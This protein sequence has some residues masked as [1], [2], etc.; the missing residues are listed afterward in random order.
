[1][2]L[3][4]H[5]PLNGNTNDISGNNYLITGSPTIMAGKIGQAY[6]FSTNRLSFLYRDYGLDF[7]KNISVSFWVYITAYPASRMGIFETAYGAE[8]AINIASDGSLQWYYGTSGV[9]AA[10]YTAFTTNAGTVEV[11]KWVHITLVR[12]IKNNALFCYKNGTRINSGTLVY[13]PVISTTYLKIGFSYTGFLNGR[14]NDFRIYDHVLTDFEIQEI[15]RAKILHYTFDDMQEPTTNITTGIISNYGGSTSYSN[16]NDL[17]R[18][19]RVLNSIVEGPYTYSRYTGTENSSNNQVIWQMSYRGTADFSKTFTVSAF[20]RGSGTCHFTLYD[21]GTS[22]KVSPNFT[23]TN[24]WTKYTYTGTFSGTYV[25]NHWVALRGILDTT[26]VDISSLQIEE[27][28]YVTEFTEGS[29]T[30]RV[31]DYSGFFNHSNPLTEA[32]TPRWTPEAKIGTGAYKLNGNNY[33]LIHKYNASN[34]ASLSLWFKSNLSTS[35][36]QI[37]MGSSSSISFGIHNDTIIGMATTNSPVGLLSGSTYTVGQWNHI[38]ITRDAS[39]AMSYY[40]NGIKI[41]NGS[42]NSWSWNDDPYG[43]IGR[44]TPGYAGSAY[45]TNGEI[46]DIRV[47]ATTLS[48]KDI[49]DLYEARAEIEQSG[50]LYARDFLSNC[51]ETVNVVTN[52]DLNTGWSKSYQTNI[53]FNEISPPAGIDSQTVG[54]DRGNAAGFWYSYGNYAPQIPGVTYTVSMYVKTRD[55]NFNIVFYTADNSEVGRYWSG[56]INVPNDGQWHRI[57]WPSFTNPTNSQSES[58]SFNFS[59]AGAIGDPSTRTWFCAPQMEA[60]SYATPF[61]STYRPAIQLPSTL[62]FAGNEVHETG[63]ANF[64]DFSTV[65]ITDGLIGYWQFDKDVK[66]YSGNNYNGT[67]V[68][69]VPILDDSTYFN[70]AVTNYIQ[71]P[72]ST[73]T[74][75]GDFTFSFFAK[76]TNISKAI[77]TIFHATNTGGNDLSLE[78]Y[79]N[80][81][82]PVLNSGS[83]FSYNTTNLNNVWYHFIVKRTGSTIEVI[84]DNIS[85]GIN[86]YPTTVYSITGAIILGHEQ[87]AVGGGFDAT[88]SFEG[89]LSNFKLFNRALTAEEIAIEY[90]TMFNNQVQIHESGVLYAK[91][92]KQY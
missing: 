78:F 8:F 56:N 80:M 51:E 25:T 7:T 86:T 41:S 45:Y 82:I 84:K 46:D 5:W 43:I 50:V 63:T 17:F 15:A 52:T 59:Y 85:L 76:F 42:N 40:I 83:Y 30:A 70:G 75:L 2:A 60:K 35:T 90:N 24:E 72:N 39:N 38:V 65:G 53:V 12:D 28:P 74:N 21:Y 18:V 73:I 33:F 62:D 69:S 79:G 37:V 68:G 4:A 64:E 81:V 23:L 61:T 54:H 11:G 66:D 1:M 22:Y 57:V 29:R 67:V 44:R 48:D 14:L 20:L 9:E 6:D 19:T 16:G 34:D 27:K 32:N 77:N 58:L 89:Y 26:T 10:P 3:I 88:Q 92:I 47:Y 91:D 87:D 31:N 71:L 36:S 55:S 13:I 49:K